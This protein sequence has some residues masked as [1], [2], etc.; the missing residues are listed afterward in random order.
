MS[1]K[2]PPNLLPLGLPRKHPPALLSKECQRRH[3]NLE[4]DFKM[5]PNGNFICDVKLLNHVVKGDGEYDCG[6]QAR[7]AVANKAIA[8]VRSWP[9]GP[10]RLPPAGL[11]AAQ[12]HR[13]PVTRSQQ[14]VANATAQQQP[15][16]SG[17]GPAVK[18]EAPTNTIRGPGQDRTTAPTAVAPPQD[19]KAREQAALLDHVRRVMGISVPASTRDNPEA[20]Q[21]FLEGLA[22][23]ARLAGARVSGFSLR[24]R[25][26]SPAAPRASPGAPAFRARSPLRERERER[27]RLSPPPGHRRGPGTFGGRGDRWVHDRYREEPLD[28]N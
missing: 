6:R 24:G 5:L 4:W 15:T 13:R 20:A 2:L 21:A 16:A 10:P 7:T 26:R 22:V 19:D 23:G 12:Y 28:Y 27:D 8:V 11:P 17:S 25:S 14:M 9:I 1:A 18:Q 3:F